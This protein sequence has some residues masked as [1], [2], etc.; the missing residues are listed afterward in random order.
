VLPRTWGDFSSYWNDMLASPRIAVGAAATEL[1]RFLLD[2]ARIRPAPVWRWY[3]V[4]TAGL[5]P[6]RVREEYALP[7]GCAERAT[8]DASLR[9]LRATWWLL[10]GPV[11]WL[12]AYLDAERRLAG[13][14][15]PHPLG[16]L[17]DAALRLAIR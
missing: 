8:F 13:R 9:A 2:P 5:L 15:D 10:P 4:M 12:P 17:V 7:F 1:A 6:A 3:R 14:R 11:R 16:R